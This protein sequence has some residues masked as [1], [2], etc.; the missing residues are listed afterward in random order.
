[1]L[2]WAWRFSYPPTIRQNFVSTDT[3]P[4]RAPVSGVLMFRELTKYTSQR[5]ICRQ[6]IDSDH[7]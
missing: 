4:C 5:S 6:V 2:P 1:M 7:L 3:L